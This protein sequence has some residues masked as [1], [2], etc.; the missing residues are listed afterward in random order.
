VLG[1]L[2][3]QINE[4]LSVTRAGLLCSRCGLRTSQDLLT[5]R[6]SVCRHAT[7]AE[8]VRILRLLG[9]RHRR[10]DVP[11]R[12]VLS[13]VESQNH[14]GT[15]Q[16]SV[17]GD[18]SFVCTCLSF[19]GSRDLVE[20]DARPGVRV[21]ACK[22]IRVRES[23]VVS[24]VQDRTFSAPKVPTDWQKL[25][26]KAFSIEPHERL[27]S[28]QAYW[29]IHDLLEKQGVDY[30]EF[31]QRMRTDVRTTLLPIN[32]FGVEFEGFGVPAVRLAQALSE[33]GIPTA[34]EGYNHSTRDHFKVVSDSSIRGESPFELV[35]PKLFGA[36]G[37]ER[38]RTLCRVVARE[39]GD[40]NVTTGLHVHVD[41]WNCTIRDARN[42]LGLW[43]RIEPVVLLLVP[44]SRR[45]N[46]YC[47][48]VTPALV[49]AVS[50]MRSISQL[51]RIDRYH[52]LNLA[53]YAR[54]GTFEFRLH[55]GTFNADKVVSWAVFVLLVTAAGRRGVDATSIPQTWE[56]VSQAVGL[57]SGTS[58]IRQAH[59]YLSQRYA[60]FSQTA[61]SGSPGAVA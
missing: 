5:G 21:A 25:V 7:E 58:V 6:Q 11:T 54:H 27:T 20:I 60:H 51:G 33:S 43:H 48:P 52:N 61:A 56:G 13:T 39:G 55:S 35:T 34:T 10:R 23:Q 44:P 3:M 8:V 47:K 24:A 40:A 17:V 38:L 29:A 18:G 57:T 49:E 45:A 14:N 41:A 50:A 30:L 9:D 22:H 2:Q 37:F 15:Y 46:S 12:E 32:A 36:H 19:L 28:A 42:L 16:V 26:F 59:R 31:E 4:N 53:A 1:D